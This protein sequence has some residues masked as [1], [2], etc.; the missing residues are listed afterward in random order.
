MEVDRHPLAYAMS[1]GRMECKGGPEFEFKTAERELPSTQSNEGQIVLITRVLRILRS[2]LYEDLSC[3]HAGI[4]I[5][6]GAINSIT[7]TW[8]PTY[9]PRGLPCRLFLC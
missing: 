4:K 9:S 7:P 5:R 8:K 1:I 3:T 6:R 2:A